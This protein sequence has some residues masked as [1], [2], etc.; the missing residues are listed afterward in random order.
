MY[1]LENCNERKVGIAILVALI[2]F[3]STRFAV[4]NIFDNNKYVYIYETKNIYNKKIPLDNFHRVD[5]KDKK[6]PITINKY[7]DNGKKVNMYEKIL[8][9]VDNKIETMYNNE[10]L[11]KLDQKILKNEEYLCE[12]QETSLDQNQGDSFNCP[13]FYHIKIDKAFYGRYKN[14]NQHCI[15]GKDGKKLDKDTL[16]KY[17]N[18]KI[19]CGNDKTDIIKNHCEDNNSCVIQIENHAMN[20][21]NICNDYFK[22]L[23][24]NYH[25]EKDNTI[26]MPRFAI[27]MF[28]NSIKVNSLY[29][30]AISE[31]YQYADIH[32]YKFKLNTG[33]Y[34]KGRDVVYM[35]LYTIIEA[36]IE[37]FKTKEYEWI[38]WV[39]GDIIL[40]NPN[41]K[42]ET[43]LPTDN[44]INFIAFADEN[45]LNAGLFFLRV[46]SWS[47]NFLK[48]AISYLYYHP[49][50]FLKYLE[51]TAMNNI[52]IEQKEESHYIIVPPWF[53]KYLKV[54]EP[55]DFLIHLAGE[56][57]KDRLANNLRKELSND[58]D[59]LSAKTNKQLRE[60]VIKYYS[61]P[62]EKQKNIWIVKNS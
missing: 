48:R 15:I 32:G 40:T 14:D 35:K 27:V 19:T 42:L 23:H 38:F 18:L 1:R 51:Q 22:Y 44:N 16:E 9:L 62:K 49:K 47:L 46:N 12:I 29:E 58:M 36:L 31:I 30:N 39:D 6:G 8:D 5:N 37:G 45:S 56:W 59:W 57:D 28:V 24:L 50:K 11:L 52:L 60:E 33:T 55:G 25:C 61:L 3:F 4:E 34:D 53:N 54:K 10:T 17:H 20:D 41:I 21:T 43:F 13:L 7:L 26:K 2:V